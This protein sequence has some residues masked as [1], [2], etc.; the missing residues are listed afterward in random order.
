MNLFEESKLI[1]K[2]I[3]GIQSSNE[4]NSMTE[5]PADSDLMD[6]KQPY[7]LILLHKAPA[8]ESLQVGPVPQLKRITAK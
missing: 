3:S 4:L 2:D 5:N 7:E 1:N 8:G 6:S